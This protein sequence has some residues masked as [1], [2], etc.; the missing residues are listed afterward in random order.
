M[1]YSLKSTYKFFTSLL[2]PFKNTLLIYSQKSSKVVGQKS[3]F[4][5]SKMEITFEFTKITTFAYLDVLIS[6]SRQCI[7][8]TLK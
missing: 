1:I 7:A 2:W 4:C 5:K 6:A 3:K 8:K